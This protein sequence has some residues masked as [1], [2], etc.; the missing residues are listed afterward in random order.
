MAGSIEGPR[1]VLDPMRVTLCLPRVPLSH[2]CC[3]ECKNIVNKYFH[4]GQAIKSGKFG[5]TFALKVPARVLKWSELVN[6]IL[7]LETT[8]KLKFTAWLEVN[9]TFGSR[10]ISI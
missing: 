5:G 6:S 10:G 1:Q 4:L 8:D 9:P 2:F 3:I 7:D